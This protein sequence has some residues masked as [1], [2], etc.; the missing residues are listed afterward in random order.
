MAV[1]GQMPDH[2]AIDKI[3]ERA[4]RNFL[5]LPQ[6]PEALFLRET[7]FAGDEIGIALTNP[8]RE[9]KIADHAKPIPDQVVSNFMG[10][11]RRKR[12]PVVHWRGT[13]RDVVN[14]ISLSNE[15]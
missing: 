6:I 11:G 4:G 5:A 1:L 15:D 10:S 2:L 14:Q 12:A 8:A 13:A 3:S 7:A 9:P